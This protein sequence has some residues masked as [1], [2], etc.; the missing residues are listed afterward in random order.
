MIDYNPKTNWQ[1]NEIVSE[2]DFNRIE[3]G[4]AD[5]YERLT[6]VKTEVDDNK[7][8]IGDLST[9]TTSNKS[10]LVSA[11]NETNTNIYTILKEENHKLSL[12][13]LDI[14]MRLQENKLIDFINKSGMGYYDT[15]RD[16][17]GVYLSHTDAIMKED[18]FVFGEKRVTNAVIQEDS[19]DGTIIISGNDIEIND[20]KNYEL[21]INEEIMKGI[22]VDNEATILSDNNP[23]D[24]TVKDEWIY[25]SN[26]SD[27]GYLYKI[28]KDGMNETKLNSDKCCCIQV[29][30][31]WIYYRNTVNGCLHK[32]KIDGT[33]RTKLN[34]E[35][36]NYIQV[37]GNHVYYK[38][39]NSSGS[40]LYKIKTDGTGKIKLNDDNSQCIRV[41]GEWIYYSNQSD[42]GRLYKIKTDGSNRK[43]LN[44]NR[45]WYINLQNDWIYYRNN[46]I[47]GSIYKLKT[48][49]TYETKLSSDS[50]S[51]VQVRGNW[52]YYCN[53]NDH[54][55]IYKIR[56]DGTSRTKLNIKSSSHIFI[57]DNYIYYSTGAHLCKIK[58]N[59]TIKLSK[60]Y[61]VKTGQEVTISEPWYKLKFNPQYFDNYNTMSLNLYPPKNN[62]DINILKN[63][64]N[65]N[66]IKASW[67]NI[68]KNKRDLWVNNTKCKI[69]NVETVDSKNQLKL[70]NN[71]HTEHLCVLDDWI[72]FKNKSDNG[73][74]YKIKKD[75]TERTKLNNEY[76]CHIRIQ[77]DWIYYLN[78]NL[79]L[80]KIKI[81][82]T[83]RTETNCYVKLL[84]V[85]QGD[86][87]YYANSY[88]YK[89]KTDFSA[90]QKINDDEAQYINVLGD[91]I[92]YSNKSDNYHIYKVKIDGTKRTKI[93]SDLAYDIQVQGDWI[94]YINNHGNR[95][96]Y[97]A[98]TNGTDKTN[99][100]IQLL[101]RII[102]DEWIYYS[103]NSDKGYLYKVNVKGEQNT[104]INEH[105]PRHMKIIDGILYY[106]IDSDKNLY[107]IPLANIYN[108][109]TSTPLTLTKGQS[110]PV[111]SLRAEV[112]GK[113]LELTNIDE[114]KYSFKLDNLNTNK[115]DLTIRGDQIEL[116][117]LVYA[118]R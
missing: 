45:A 16:S 40:Y 6:D 108:I 97:K 44:N 115:V 32:I 93:I 33:E 65:S 50:A 53:S 14:K 86:W 80:R 114:E 22:G 91:W 59:K 30:D 4:V 18:G 20:N 17:D 96:L 19:N 106:V 52:I 25:Y 75:G 98:R 72:Y 39:T 15:F 49:G 1:R 88:L 83:E 92:Y 81:N 56:I 85:V 34:N 77:N 13:L 68:L 11:I 71:L 103:N 66:Q 46:S 10:D 29:Y 55:F 74:L 76:S 79:Y 87:I 105:V 117:S 116:D 3:Q 90:K 99:M 100:K 48:D 111:V 35:D 58:T 89:M 104:K 21:T 24:I 62:K 8:K 51:Y 101:D 110:I 113:P 61:T 7:N 38:M 12:E 23:V 9:L 2:S 47:N 64:K 37:Q 84:Y 109:T 60:L 95:Y 27:N 57:E 36:S 69:N 67:N 54:S 42:N 112:N 31:E 82:G 43:K 94:Y 102:Y 70:I 28:K 5:A 63:I 107:K 26:Y 78:E 118:V 73:C 41:N